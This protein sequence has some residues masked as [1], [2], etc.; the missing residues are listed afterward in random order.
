MRS[1]RRWLE[2]FQDGRGAGDGSGDGPGRRRAFGS[3]ALEGQAVQVV[4]VDAPGRGA[5]D[6]P[7][8]VIRDAISGKVLGNPAAADCGVRQWDAAAAAGGAR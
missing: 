3:L 1:D 6:G 7:A 2:L 8:Y 5:L 4:A